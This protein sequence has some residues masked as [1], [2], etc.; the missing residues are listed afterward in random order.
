MLSNPMGN[1]ENKHFNQSFGRNLIQ[2]ASYNTLFFFF[3]SYMAQHFSKVRSITTVDRFEVI[4]LTAALIYHTVTSL[5][6]LI[7][8]SFLHS[9]LLFQLMLQ[10]G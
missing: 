6:S 3:P 9:M 7:T 5:S 2:L 4:S 10:H 8:P 1:S